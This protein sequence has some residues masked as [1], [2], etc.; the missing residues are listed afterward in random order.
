MGTSTGTIT[1][2]RLEYLAIASHVGDVQSMLE[3]LSHSLNIPR[4]TSIQ[5]QKKTY[6]KMYTA[7]L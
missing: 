7:A 1:L 6:P 3:N 5:A 2:E 4:E